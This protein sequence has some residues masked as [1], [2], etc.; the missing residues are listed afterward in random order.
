MYVLGIYDEN[1]KDEICQRVN[2]E[3]K[4]KEAYKS[5]RKR[6]GKITVWV[7]KVEAIDTKGWENH[8]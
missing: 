2:T 5:L 8:E 6:Y 3:A 1:G 4:A 7:D